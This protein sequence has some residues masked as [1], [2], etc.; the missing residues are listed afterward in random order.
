M[1]K[2]QATVD[3]SAL[4]E[5]L[6]LYRRMVLIRRFEEAVQSLFL[7]GEIH[8]TTHL[9]SGQEASVVGVVSTLREGDR[10]AA[11]YRGHG[12][13]LA[14]GTPP[15]A[16]MAELCGRATGVCG[17]RA[18]SM[19]VVDLEHGLIGCFG[20]VGAS[21]AAAIGAG[22]AFKQRG[23]PH[24]AVAFF[25]DGATNQAYFH[26]C[27]N[28]AQ[29]EKLPVVFV[30]ENNLYMEFTPIE[31]VTAG[32]I[33]DR[34]RVFGIPSESVDGNDVWTVREAAGRAIEHARSG[35]GPAFVENLTYRLVGHSRSDPGR[36]RKPGELE[37]WRERE[38]LVIARRELAERHGLDEA[39][40]DAVDADVAREMEA[41]VEHALAAPW[42]SPDAPASEFKS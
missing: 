31:T 3:R 36:Y 1:A 9:C 13:V 34:P 41:V 4:E 12:A 29:V 14:L 27:L 37:E 32:R 20:I 28:F 35:E 10:V 38:P 2:R 8:G 6:G 26:E 30:C 19:N 15:E 25:G 21:M 5:D 17:G 40:I 42:P 16:F 7:K 39:A 18:G 33:A 11:T 22:L 23:L 24:V